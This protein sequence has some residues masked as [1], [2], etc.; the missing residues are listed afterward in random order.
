MGIVLSYQIR[1][2]IL[3]NPRLKPEK[4]VLVRKM[5]MST[6]FLMAS[7]LLMTTVPIQMYKPAF[8]TRTRTCP[9]TPFALG[10]WGL[11]EP[12]C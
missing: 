1:P 5:C 12:W 2:R 8:P 6:F 3:R 7:V 4:I 10:F 9:S 11:L